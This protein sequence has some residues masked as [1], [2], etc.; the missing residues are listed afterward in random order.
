M[1]RVKFGEMKEEFKRILIKKGCNEETAN[2][3]AELYTK[4]SCDGI[5]SHGV[6]RFPRTIEYVEK[7]YIDMNA[8]PTVEM[9][10]GAIERWNGNL[11]F[12]NLNAELAMER[13]IELAKQN[14]I[15]CVA[16]KNTN[17]W[18]RGGT[19]GWQAAEAGCIGICWTN[20]QPNMPAWGSKERRIGNNP[21]IFSAPRKN[22]AV[23]VDMACAQFSYG[24]M[25]ATKLRGELLPVPGGYNLKGEITCDPI[26]IEKTWRVLPIG[27]WKGSGL[28]IM[29]DLIASVLS[30]GNSCEKVGELG[31]DEYGL[32]QVLIAIDTQKMSSEERVEEMINSTIDYVKSSE[33][34]EIDGRIYYPGELELLKREENMKYG[35]PVN[36]EIWKKI[37][38]L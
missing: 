36:K 2:K 7:G 18:L 22:G 4:T 25:E 31:N 21:I 28:S 37:K 14:G 32:S 17:H 3:V 9:K 16:I 24:Q 27:F 5:Y 33:P 30:D 1:I 19:F 38:N 20:T 34:V 23:V 13:A 12:G 8:V 6:N 15:G 26:E 35:I 11:G 10:G 29:L